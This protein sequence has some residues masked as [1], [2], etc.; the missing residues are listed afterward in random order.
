MG[1]THEQLVVRMALAALARGKERGK[2]GARDN[3][4]SVPECEK[5]I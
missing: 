2:T 5:L 1:R 3:R 4:I